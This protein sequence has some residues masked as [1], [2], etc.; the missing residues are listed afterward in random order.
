M[1]AHGVEAASFPAEV[2]GHEGEV[3]EALDVVDAADVFGDAER[4]VDGGA[5]GLTVPEGGFFDV[6]GWHFGDVGGP[7]WGEGLDVLEEFGASGGAVLEE[8][9]VYEVFTGDDVSHCQE[10][11]D[12]GANANR[13][14]KVG[15]IGERDFARINDDHFG[16]SA[17]GFFDSGG[18][19]WMA[20]GHVGAD[21]KEDVGFLHV[22]EGVGHGASAD[23]GGQTGHRGR[24]SSAAAVI[25]LMGA[26]AGADELLHEVVGFGRGAAGGDAVNAVPS[27]FLGGFAEAFGGAV[28]GFFPGGF[29]EI[30]VFAPDKRGFETV[31]MLNEIEG[32]LAFDAQGA[33]IGR[34]VHGRL[35]AD[36]SISFGQKING[37]SD[38]AVGANGSSFLNFS[39]NRCGA[40]GFFVGQGAGR[41]GLHAL[42]AKGAGGIFEVA[43]KLG[44]DLGVEAAVADADGVVAF[45]LGADA[46]ATIAGNA[47]VVVAQDEGIGVF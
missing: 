4:I 29:V 24:V 33:V 17:Q 28:Q 30:A 31:G 46:H 15:K 23:G 36:Q 40:H 2:A 7:F 26:E 12:V 19:D 13:Q 3:A 43:G 6:G 32:E 20:F 1:A 41:A 25:D 14:I 11:G 16:A 18:G 22:G 34:A 27:V 42:A 35:Y 45:L 5:V 47:S 9:R 10:Q 39:G 44:C 21:A 8:G 37:A 38:A